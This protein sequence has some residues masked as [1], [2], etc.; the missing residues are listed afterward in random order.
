MKQRLG[1]GA[2]TRVRW[3]FEP[4]VWSVDDLEA[5]LVELADRT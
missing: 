1:T 2:K 4:L 3:N 5:E